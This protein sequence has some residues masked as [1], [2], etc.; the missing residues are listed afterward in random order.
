MNY[1]HELWF[2]LQKTLTKY[3]L[4]SHGIRKYFVSY[5][6]RRCKTTLIAQS[7]TGDHELT[8][9]SIRHIF[10][11]KWLT[12]YICANDLNLL[13]LWNQIDKWLESTETKRERERP[14][15]QHWCCFVKEAIPKKE[16]GWVRFQLH[17]DCSLIVQVSSKGRE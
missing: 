6:L 11:I 9:D 3:Q 2:G 17:F 15:F 13:N 16:N 1:Y 10:I 12:L 8:Y 7:S 5:L 4:Y 14:T